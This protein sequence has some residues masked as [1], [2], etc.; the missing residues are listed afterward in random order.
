[1][2]DVKQVHRKFAT[3]LAVMLCIDIACAAVLF[4]PIGR[5]SRN[6]RKVESQVW[7]EL[8]TKTR[9]TLPLNGLDGKIKDAKSEIKQFYEQRF[10]DRFAKVPEELG[11]LAAENGV[12]LSA[13]RYSTADTDVPG[14]HLVRVEAAIDGDYFKE[15]KF[16]N[17]VERDKTFFIINSVMLGGEQ[18]GGVHLQIVFET[19]VRSQA[20]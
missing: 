1:M 3:I 13:A 19:Y 4:S 11:K 10:P 9:Q 18:K 15:A 16:I 20:A 2:A 17:A 14:I 12:R 8:Q 6:G 7:S 5:A